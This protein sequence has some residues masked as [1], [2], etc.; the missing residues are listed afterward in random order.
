MNCHLCFGVKDCLHSCPSI[1]DTHCI[2]FVIIFVL[3]Y[4]ISVSA[5]GTDCQLSGCPKFL[6]IFSPSAL[7]GSTVIQFKYDVSSDKLHEPTVS[8]V[9][10]TLKP[11][12]I[13]PAMLPPAEGRRSR[14]GHL[15][16]VFE[17]WFWFF[18][19][20]FL[21]SFVQAWEG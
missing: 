8:Y 17:F 9:A 20:L 1:L 11:H 16:L 14:V 5:A 10:L 7:E 12:I 3:R 15:F 21:F 18:C 13:P 4:V 19:L 6:L 2:Q